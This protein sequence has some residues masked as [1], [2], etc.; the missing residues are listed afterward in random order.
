MNKTNQQIAT[1]RRPMNEAAVSGWN[2]INHP[3]RGV[4]TKQLQ[5]T[6][7]V[8]VRSLKAA[9][10]DLLDEILGDDTGKVGK[11]HFQRPRRTFRLTDTKKADKARRSQDRVFR[12]NGRRQTWE[13]ML[14]N[15]PA[16]GAPEVMS[17]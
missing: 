6:G 14:T 17:R 4:L 9:G 8:D 7:P 2:G 1:D 5:G 12:P 11:R 13:T 15:T 16:T 10:T 3:P